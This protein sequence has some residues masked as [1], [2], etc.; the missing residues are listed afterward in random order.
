MK[1]ETQYTREQLIETVWD[2][3]AQHNGQG[4]VARLL[5]ISPAYLSDI[6]NKRREI[7]QNVAKQLGFYR[8]TVFTKLA[9]N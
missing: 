1:H 5:G 4:N 8:Q 2:L 9:D 3:V 7:S 6:L